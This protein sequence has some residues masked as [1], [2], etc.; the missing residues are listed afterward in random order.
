ML[1]DP[2]IMSGVWLVIFYLVCLILARQVCTYECVLKC[3][4]IHRFFLE[5][6]H[7][8]VYLPWSKISHCLLG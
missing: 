3:S 8:C 2:Q 6:H 1:K 5:L 4:F 7:I